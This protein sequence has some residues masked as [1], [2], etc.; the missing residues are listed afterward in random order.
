[1]GQAG[2]SGSGQAGPAPVI[3]LQQNQVTGIAITQET[4]AL[5]TAAQEVV[6][7]AQALQTAVQQ[8]QA[9]QSQTVKVITR[10]SL[11]LLGLLALTGLVVF[12]MA[13]RTQIIKINKK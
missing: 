2:L 7:Q 8:Q 1:M 10:T 3:N 12:K 4:Q 9:S 11:A 5:Q 6:Q 13:G